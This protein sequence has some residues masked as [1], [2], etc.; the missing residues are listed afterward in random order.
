MKHEIV[1]ALLSTR[2]TAIVRGIEKERLFLTTDALRAGGVR[3][4]EVTFDTPGAAEMIQSLK[5]RYGDGLLIGA[6]TVLDTETCRIA[7]LSGADFVLAPSLNTAVIAMCNRYGKVAVPGV[8]T[9][10]EIVSALEAG[11]ELIKLFPA[12]ALGPGYIKDVL[13]P[14]KQAA[15]MAVGGID[16][17]NAADFFAAGAKALGI[18]SSLVSRQLI[19]EGKYEE[20]T[21]R[22][23]FFTSL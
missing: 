6:G 16:Q 12:G 21:A 2:I 3:S 13:G 18:G 19:A 15:L 22:A 5:E 23:R 4:I 17:K 7:L 1:S 9:P 11:S 8:T 10:T 20:I 14:L